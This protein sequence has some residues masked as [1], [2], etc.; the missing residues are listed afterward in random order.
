MTTWLLLALAVLAML[1]AGVMW[2]A[3]VRPVP[4]RSDSGVIT[5][6]TFIPARTIEHY[7]GGARSESFSRQK[8][9]MPD[10]YLFGIRVQGRGETVQISIA[11]PAGA[12][13]EVGQNVRVRYAERG[14]PLLSRRIQ[15]LEMTRADA[16]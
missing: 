6:K 3:Y 4:E 12:K 14:I 16:P 2:Y 15:V 1:F 8:I 9:M 11:A 10:S 7:Q 13:F 5:S